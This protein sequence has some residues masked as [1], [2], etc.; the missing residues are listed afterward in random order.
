MA[1]KNQKNIITDTTNYYSTLEVM[2]QFNCSMQSVGRY[3]EKGILE[4]VGY[5]RD[6]G[7]KLFKREQVRY[8]KPLI[9]FYY[10]YFVRKAKNNENHQRI[11]G[12]NQNQNGEAVKYISKA[13][14]GAANKTN[15]N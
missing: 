11:N 1:N 15:S 13:A 10:K 6:S 5:A 7:S 2:K 12:G 4:V 9:K 3:V 8:L 14:T